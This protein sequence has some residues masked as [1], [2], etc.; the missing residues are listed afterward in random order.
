[1]SHPII[2]EFHATYLRDERLREA[3]T[4]RIARAQGTRTAPPAERTARG[5]AWLG[6]QLIALGTRL[7]RGA[8]PAH[9]QPR[10]AV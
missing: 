6:G 10:R 9:A 1:M 4:H 8:Q 7:T 2:S 3:T 5:R